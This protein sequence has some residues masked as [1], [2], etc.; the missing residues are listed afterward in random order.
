[1]V[2][3]YISLVKVICSLLSFVFR[4][5]QPLNPVPPTETRCNRGLKELTKFWIY[6]MKNLIMID[7]P[8]N[9]T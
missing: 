1:M 5:A 7:G 2:S 9:I 8:S 4:N 3:R 6:M